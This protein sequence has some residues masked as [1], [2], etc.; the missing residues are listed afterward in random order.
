MFY[1]IK[2]ICNIT[3]NENEISVLL[4]CIRIGRH[5]FQKKNNN[6]KIILV[7]YIKLHR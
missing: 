6:N 2:G 3:Q 7:C 4:D 5:V 1:P